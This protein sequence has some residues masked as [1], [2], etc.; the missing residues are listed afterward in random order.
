MFKSQ[1]WVVVKFF[2]NTDILD[3]QKLDQVFFT[4]DAAERRAE[5]MQRRHNW[6]WRAVP[7]EIDIAKVKADIKEELAARGISTRIKK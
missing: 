3:C 1:A 5:R 6:I 2:G 4:Q 7:C